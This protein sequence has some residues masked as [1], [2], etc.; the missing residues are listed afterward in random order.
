MYFEDY[1]KLK[2][3]FKYKEFKRSKEFEFGNS[4]SNFVTLSNK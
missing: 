4:N 2:F 1:Y 3:I